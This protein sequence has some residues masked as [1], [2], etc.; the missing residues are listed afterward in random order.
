MYENIISFVAK[1]TNSG[2][3]YII[4]QVIEELKRRGN[5]VAAVKHSV[6]LPSVDKEGKDTYKFAQKGAERIIIFSDNALMLYEMS[7]PDIEYLT[8]LASKDIDIVIVEGFKSG[9]FKKIEVFNKTLYESP[10]CLEKPRE[11]FIAIISDTY[12]N[13]GIKHFTFDDI[14]GICTFVEEQAANAVP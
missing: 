9:P 11:E 6:H 3:T 12:V 1:G 2:K 4:E 7:C 8:S 5:K 10:L 14:P 13:A